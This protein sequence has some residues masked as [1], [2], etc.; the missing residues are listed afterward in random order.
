MIYLFEQFTIDTGQYQLSLDG[1][2]IPVEPLVFDILVYLI[3]NRERVVGRD[4]LLKSLWQGKVVTDSALGI[5]VKDA[6]KAL[7]DSGDRQ[8]IIKTVHG[9]GYQFIARIDESESVSP[10]QKIEKI[11][12]G[13]PLDLPTKLS[14][15]VLPLQNDSDDIDEVYF[16]EGVTDGII[17]NLTRFRDLFVMGRSS[18]FSF[19][20]KIVDLTEIGKQLGVRYLV[21]GTVR[22]IGQRARISIELIDA[23]TCQIL[24]SERYD[25]ELEDV[26]AVED[27]VSRDIVTNLAI[28]VEGAVYRHSQS[29]TPENLVAYEWVLRGNRFLERGTKSDLLEALR[30][31]EKAVELDPNYSAA[32]TG[33]SQAYLNLHWGHLAEDHRDI[34][35]QSL[36]FGQKAVALDDQD[37]RGHYA[38]G[39]AYL[40][41]AQHDLAEFHIERALALNPS[42]YENLCFK[43][44]LLA[45]TGR[46]DESESCFAQSM[47]RN[48]LA[49]NGCLCGLGISDYLAGRYEE[50]TIMLTRMSSD[51]VRKFSCLAASHAQLGHDTRAHEA[52]QEFRDLMEPD[53]VS[54]LEEDPEKWRENWSYMYSILIPE[55][56]EHLLE[57]LRKAGLPA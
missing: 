51:P 35:N 1:K 4:E 31:Y 6:R 18:S 50:A 49:P 32:Y 19:R 10:S 39:H 30:M 36:E 24:W 21:Q 38:I 12:S 57:G 47:R 23:I 48:P 20:D 44:Y 40:C 46:Y 22:K 43:G 55:D 14:I 42:E 41:L 13:L 37:S 25:R 8:E 17:N 28:Q 53:Q 26:F 29:R 33:L 27:E 3:Q 54:R 16:S 52:A 7:G 34:M 15:A 5:R 2:P 9:R 45:C 11:V 56:F